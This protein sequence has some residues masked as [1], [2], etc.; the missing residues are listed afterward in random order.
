MKFK[1]NT[2]YVALFISPSLVIAEQAS[3]LT[4]VN[5]NTSVQPENR[6]GTYQSQTS[7]IANKGTTP[8]IDSPQTVNIVNNQLIRDR[9]PQNIDEALST[10][11]GVTQA[12]NLGGLFDAV[13]KR[14]FGKNRDNSIIRNG[15]PSGPSHNFGATTERVEVLKGPA[16]VLYGIQD[17]GGVINIVT[18]QPLKEARYVIGTTVGNHNMWGSEVDFSGPLTNGFSYRFIFDKQ[19]KNYWR[20][21]GR[22]E[23]TTYAPSLSWENEQ[24]KIVLGYEHLDYREPF[25]RGTVMIASGNDRGKLVPISARTRLDDPTNIIT[26]KSDRIEFK[27]EHRLNDYWRLNGAYSYVREYYNYWQTR[28]QRVNL[29]TGEAN[30]RFEGIQNANQRIH[31]ISVNTTGEFA[32]GDIA[33]RLVIGMDTSRNYRDIYPRVEATGNFG[34]N[35]YQPAY[36][37]IVPNNLQIA[38]NNAQQTDH[39]KTVGVYLQNSAYLT[40]KLIVSAGLRYEYYDQM[41][42]RGGRTAPFTANTNSYDGKFLYQGGVVYKFTPNWVIYTNYAESFRPQSQIA[43][44]VSSTMKPELGKSIEMGTKYENAHFST[45]LALF[46]IN[47]QNV[48]YTSNNQTHLKGKV[49]SRG[50]E[51]D[52]N[53]KLTENLGVTATYAYTKTKNISDKEY[54]ILEGREFEGVPKHQASLFLTYDFGNFAFGS[55]RMGAGARYIGSWFVDNTHSSLRGKEESYKLPHSVVND[56]FIAFDTKLGNKKVSLQLNGKNLTNKTYY[57]STVGTNNDVIP[58]QLGYGREF[59]LNT[60]F[61]F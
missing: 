3:S 11:S 13:L 6:E 55:I 53:G 21:F 39:L 60:Q 1:H 48:A 26:G 54:P 38:A 58:I 45:N 50:L 24:T 12:N 20:N 47:K 49:R 28:T 22:I 8:L 40:E 35:I 5:V 2:I 32:V 59:L 46:N 31:S 17:P 9:K 37:N 10:V 57:T 18:K 43:S 29:N 36:L 56:A 61:E 4:E 19:E 16:S 41:A 34:I 51:W 44:V 52:I 7:N 27:I 23:R 15:M 30:R 33:N 25:D 14:G 42:G